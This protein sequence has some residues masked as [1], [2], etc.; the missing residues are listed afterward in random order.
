MRAER[1]G[2]RWC[3]SAMRH[4]RIAGSTAAAAAR[5]G[6]SARRAAGDMSDGPGTL[7]QPG[8]AA[9]LGSLVAHF[10]TLFERPREVDEIV[11]ANS[12][13]VELLVRGSGSPGSRVMLQTLPT[14]DTWRTRVRRTG[15]CRASSSSS[16]IPAIHRAH[17][18]TARN[19][20]ARSPRSIRPMRRPRG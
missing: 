12:E 10:G 3:T 7:P 16:S 4:T 18:S 8:D 13:R 5:W 11:L 17:R 20:C 2:G 1:L 9:R 14:A 19:F 15:M 6:Y